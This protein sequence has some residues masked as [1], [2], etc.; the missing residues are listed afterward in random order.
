MRNKLAKLLYLVGSLLA[1][2][3][4]C[5]T[6]IIIAILLSGGFPALY[7]SPYMAEILLGSAIG[8]LTIGCSMMTCG[9]HLRQEPDIMPA[10]AP[11]PVENEM[12]QV[13]GQ[14]NQSLAARYEMEL[15]MRQ[16][17]VRVA[18]PE[19]NVELE[20]VPHHPVVVDPVEGVA[21]HRASLWRQPQQEQPISQ[22]EQVSLAPRQG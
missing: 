9:I 11:P 5:S 14:F 17:E 1:L 16:Q 8:A 20:G 4:P 7:D 3:G 10:P 22:E 15:A 12:S 13:E 6:V 18:V 19:V 2:L 21:N